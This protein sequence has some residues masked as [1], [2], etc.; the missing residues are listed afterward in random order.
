MRIIP[1]YIFLGLFIGL[2][3]VYITAPQPKVIIKY[4]TPDNAGQT[5]YVDDANVCYKYIS[6]ERKC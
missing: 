4:P 1:I 6:K 3:F 5:T 2:Y